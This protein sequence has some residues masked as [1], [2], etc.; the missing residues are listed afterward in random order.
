M[1]WTRVPGNMSILLSTNPFIS[2]FQI[3]ISGQWAAACVVQFAWLLQTFYWTQHPQSQNSQ[4]CVCMSHRK[5]QG[6]TKLLEP[7]SNFQICFTKMIRRT[8][9]SWR[10]IRFS[11]ARFHAQGR[12]VWACGMHANLSIATW[13]LIFLA[14]S[15]DHSHKIWKSSI[16]LKSIFF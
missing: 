6:I 1:I 7:W 11:R 10:C 14:R 4:P 8:C 12:P 15:L 13:N 3:Q 9:N 5:I 2:R 16:N